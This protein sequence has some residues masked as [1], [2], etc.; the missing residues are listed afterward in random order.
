MRYIAVG[1][2]EPLAWLQNA[3][4][5]ARALVARCPV[6]DE[7]LRLLE[8]ELEGLLSRGGTVT[9]LVPE[10]P[11]SVLGL[12]D[13]FL[14]QVI[15]ARVAGRSGSRVAI[16]VS[17]ADASCFIGDVSLEA[18]RLTG[19]AS[20]VLMT[21]HRDV[22][23]ALKII[24]ALR[25]IPGGSERM[26]SLLDLMQPTLDTLAE[27]AARI[28]TG[29]ALGTG[30]ADLDAVTAGSLAGTVWAV[31]GNGGVGKTALALTAARHCAVE[32]GSQV[33]WFGSR[34]LA[35]DLVEQFLAAEARV[36]LHDLRSGRASN[37]AW[38]RL[39]R[40]MSEVARTPLHY[41][42]IS[43]GADSALMIEAACRSHPEMG[44]VVVDS[45]R[46]E[47][48]VVTLERLKA[49]AVDTGAWVLAVVDADPD[50]F[51]ARFVELAGRHVDLI[52]EVHRDGHGDGGRLRVGAADLIV[53]RHRLGPLSVRLS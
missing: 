23:A 46:A 38:A 7:G 19:G 40:R 20:G 48:V 39:S 49:L 17:D 42:D 29:P 35:M 43:G 18:S 52:L 2:R 3:L 9:L 30:L 44:L 5:K 27:R 45:L 16:E 32:L 24:E 15:V 21:S 37:D 36:P 8:Q 31:T 22:P 12:R 51:D 6:D 53:S 28:T 47:S 10:M 26:T 11:E 14:G 13:R 50:R 1:S 33:L 34:G 25:A 41:T 4:P